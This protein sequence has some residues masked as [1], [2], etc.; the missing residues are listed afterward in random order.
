MRVAG[1]CNVELGAQHQR[2]AELAAAAHGLSGYGAVVT[3]NKIHQAETQGL[4][5]R[6]TGNLKGV[7]NRQRRL[8]QHVQRQSRSRGRTHIRQGFDNALNIGCRID[9][10]NHQVAQPVT[11][12]ADDGGNVRLKGRMVNRVHTRCHAG[13]GGCGQQQRNHQRGVISLAAHG[14]AVFAVQRDVKHAG[15]EL[16]A[17]LGLQL[18]AFAHA[19][20]N[21]AVVVANRQ[22]AGCGLSAKKNVT[23]VLH[24]VRCQPRQAACNPYSR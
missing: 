12:L 9:L 13:T 23:R 11:R 2:M 10:G 18:Q 24:G 15:A 5:A 1:R 6:L 16:L 7:V 21:A 19:R 8:D 4:H 14:R 17:H 3:G 20:L 22:N